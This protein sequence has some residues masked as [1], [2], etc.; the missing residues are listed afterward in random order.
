MSERDVQWFLRELSAAWGALDPRAVAALHDAPF[1]WSSPHGAHA[2]ADAA[3][4]ESAFAARIA[5]Y[6]ERGVVQV[7]LAET[8]IHAPQFLRVAVF[9]TVE[10]TW[11]LWRADRTP[12]LTYHTSH[13]VR[14]TPAGWRISSTASHDEAAGFPSLR[15]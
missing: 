12:M 5:L 15:G 1:L 6:R 9:A 13:I 10:A 4:I 7:G 14:R 8:R 3:A 11:R 2:Y